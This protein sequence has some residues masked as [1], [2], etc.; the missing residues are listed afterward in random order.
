MIFCF[1]KHSSIVYF[2][3]EQCSFLEGGFYESNSYFKRRNHC[4]LSE[5]CKR[6]GTGSNQHT[7]GCLRM[8]HGS[9]FRLQ[10]FSSKSELL[11]A[12]IENIWKDIFHMSASQC[13]FSDFVECLNWLFDSVQRGSQMYPEFFS[14]H[15]MVFASEDQKAGHQMMEK[16]FRHLEENL[17]NVLRRDPNVREDAFDEVLTPELF[18]SYVLELF[19][20]SVF[21]FQKD[22]RGI[23]EIVRRCLYAPAH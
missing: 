16:Y 3:L 10:L 12:A 2:K 18:I 6:A 21:H 14:R 5:D 23:L 7:L 17:L 11:C 8:W 13:A 1:D 15:A 20:S 9:W 22:Y 19:V 4:R